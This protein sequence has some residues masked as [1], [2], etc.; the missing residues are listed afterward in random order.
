MA[1]G[2]LG[3]WSQRKQAVRQGKPVA[4]VVDEVA[5]AA[6]SVVLAAQ[7]A[8]VPSDTRLP[9]G[10]GERN[11]DPLAPDALAPQAP[12]PTMQDVSALNAESDFKPFIA[13]AVAPEVRNAAMKKLFADPHFN[14]M[15]GLDTYIDDYSIPDPLPASMLR[16]MAS[17]Q[18]LKLFDDEEKPAPGGAEPDAPGRA[19]PAVAQAESDRTNAAASDPDKTDPPV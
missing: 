11:A 8:G 10:A 9:P 5:P 16:K 2:F 19:S 18:F 4:G 1:D 7:P 15:D 12:P 14:V 17:A 6:A 13:R 3:R